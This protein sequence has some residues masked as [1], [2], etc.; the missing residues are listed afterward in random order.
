ME[1]T[2]VETWEHDAN[3]EN[4]SVGW[5]YA[6]NSMLFLFVKMTSIDPV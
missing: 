6:N 5:N 3:F 1:N 4:K 2:G